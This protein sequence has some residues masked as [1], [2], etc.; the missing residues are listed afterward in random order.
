LVD[1]VRASASSGAIWNESV[2]D[3]RR[4]TLERL[5]LL[6]FYGCAL[7][8][9]T[10]SLGG[11]FT[12]PIISEGADPWAVF[13]DG[14][15][16]LTD[17][18]GGDVKVRQATRLAG[19][20]GI[21]TASPVRIF[22][23]PAPYNQGVWAPE[24]HFIQGKAYIYYAAD[25]GTN[26]NHR[27]F[28][29]EQV[30][31]TTTFTSKGKVYDATTDCWAIDGTVLQ[32]TN[33]AL[34][35]IWSGWPGA[36]NGL[37]NLYIAPMS[38]PWTISGPRVLLS[39]PT[40]SWESWI[41]EGPAILQRNGKVFVIYAANLSWTDDECLGMLVNTNGN[42]LDPAAWTKLPQPVF[43]TYT[44]AGGSVFGPG[45]CSFSR[46]L[47]GAEDWLFYHAAT[48]SGA[49]WDR[50][51]RMQRFTW[52]ANG[53]PSFGQPVPAGVALADP[54]GDDFTPALIQP[55]VIQTNRRALVTARAPLPLLTNQW[56][57]EYS[58]DL[59]RWSPLTNVPGLQFLATVLDVPAASNRF[60]RVR[61]QR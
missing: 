15:Y 14:Y 33:G 2:P 50:N 52:D 58:G 40:K 60:Y 24:L 43:K 6:W 35:F 25:N 41:Q 8:A 29:A 38:D 37:Q 32:A 49:G 17:T 46:S 19:T 4:S 11:T 61:S 59:K 12:N 36:S 26:E 22:K 54:A 20:N 23:P 27:M 48:N 57:V 30:G 56:T 51:I 21:G 10:S 5:I 55:L 42:Y 9:A 13:K 39:T 1:R 16:Y 28:C 53:Y 34:Y 18:T 44:S 3:R 47:D 31:Q 7:C 45:H